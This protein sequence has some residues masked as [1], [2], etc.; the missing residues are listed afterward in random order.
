MKGLFLI[1][2]RGGSQGIPGKNLKPLA[3][4]P[5]LYYT[6]DTARQLAPDADICLSTDSD[7]IIRAAADYGLVVPFKRPAELATNQAGSYGVLR[8]AVD[9]Y[10]Q[11]GQIYD[12]VVLLQPT[13][14][15]RQARHVREAINLYTPDLDMVVSVTESAANPYFNLFEETDAGF[16]A[17]SKTGDFGRRQDAPTVYAYNGAVYV[18]N[19]ASLAERTLRE[20]ASVKKYV[21]DPADSVDLDTPLDWAFAEFLMQQRADGEVGSS[22]SSC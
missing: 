14:P 15:F 8:H 1:P 9:F 21:M 3:G 19:P 4:K 13:S 2:A 11:Q 20:F 10:G 12:M 16:L 6:I 5:L 18:I 22:V 17:P 7:E